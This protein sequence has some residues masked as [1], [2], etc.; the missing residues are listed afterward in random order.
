MRRL[1]GSTLVPSCVAMQH[2][3]TYYKYSHGLFLREGFFVVF[4]FAYSFFCQV[5][6][7]VSSAGN[8]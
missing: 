5:M 3:S 1:S 4:H 2:M 8:T 6:E 7:V